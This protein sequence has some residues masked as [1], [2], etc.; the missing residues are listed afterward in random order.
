MTPA[1][2]ILT[3]GEF[4]AAFPGMRGTRPS[5]MMQISDV[6]VRREGEGFALLTYRERQI[7]DSG[8]TDR[9]STVMLLERSDRPTPVWHHLQE[10]MQG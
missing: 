4:A 7:Q 5:L 8:T 6:V 3:F 2:K 10:T 9:I 1:G